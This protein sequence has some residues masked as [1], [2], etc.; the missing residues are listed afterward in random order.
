MSGESGVPGGDPRSAA[1]DGW[2]WDALLAFI[3]E[4]RVIPIVGPDLLRIEV[5]GVPTTFDH[6]VAKQLAGR[7]SVPAERLPADPSLNDVVSEY[8]SMGRGARQDLYPKIRNIVREASFPPPRPLVQLAEIT[9]IDLF[10]TTTFDGLLENA[11]DT[12]RFGGQ[13]MTETIVYKP[14]GGADLPRPKETLARTA[15]FHL[16]GRASTLPD[17]VISDEDMLEFIFS[18]QQ[19]KSRPP[20]LFDAFRDNHLL[21]LGVNFADWLARFFLRVAKPGRLSDPRD[22]TEVL[23][24]SKMTHDST[25]LVF[26]HHFSSR[27]KI[28]IGGGA[29]EFVDGLWQRW[30]ALN[31]SA[32]ARLSSPFAPPPADMPEGAIFISYA[33]ED[34]AAVQQLK[35]GLE[36]EGLTVWFD[37]ERLEAGE[38]FDRK[39]RQNIRACSLFVPVLSQ[40]AA[41]RLEG[42]FRREWRYA[43]DRD[44]NISD[45]KAFIIPVVV[46][47]TKDVGWIPER[48]QE[49]HATWLPQGQPT[50]EFVQRMR[51]ITGADSPR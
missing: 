42:Y 23:A 5:D 27:T 33:R 12:A 1:E 11:L 8:V 41:R 21:L 18:L 22:V 17:Y 49:L 6:Y 14:K 44:M 39:I 47:D 28:F 45:E 37:F 30:R 34:F 24:D 20:L 35:A 2:D 43:L 7:M 40:N 16:F 4:R 13:P 48:F 36:A 15:I 3:D 25:L 32:P 31:R 51:R 46:D 26:L 50:S 29:V 38:A 9:D 10:V 19:E